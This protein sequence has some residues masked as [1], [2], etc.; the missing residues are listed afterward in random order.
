MCSKRQALGKRRCTHFFQFVEKKCRLKL[1]WA[2]VVGK[3]EKCHRQSGDTAKRTANEEEKKKR[4]QILRVFCLTLWTERVKRTR[5][6]FFCFRLVR[7]RFTERFYLAAFSHSC[8]QSDSAKRKNMLRISE[9]TV[10]H[11]CMYCNA[12]VWLFWQCRR[13]Y[14]TVNL[15]V[16][17]A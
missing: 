2:F 11:I 8:M 17:S 9:R 16:H 3:L 10:L 1:N 7:C 12:N 13:I 4:K 15:H 14:S 5:W 6:I